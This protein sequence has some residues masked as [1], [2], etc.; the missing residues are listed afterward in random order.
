VNLGAFST[1][2]MPR[3]CPMDGM[4]PGLAKSLTELDPEDAF[5]RF[6]SD[7]KHT[8]SEYTLIVFNSIGRLQRVKLPRSSRVDETLVDAFRFLT[9]ALNEIQ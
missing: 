2:F 3:I 8:E 1:T 9:G 5:Q 4:R 6:L 7:K